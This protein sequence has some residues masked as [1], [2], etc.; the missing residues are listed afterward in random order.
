MQNQNLSIE[1][2]NQEHELASQ[3]LL[4]RNRFSQAL[5]LSRLAELGGDYL[6]RSPINVAVALLHSQNLHVRWAALD[7]IKKDGSGWTRSVVEEA[8]ARETD[9]RLQAAMKSYLRKKRRVATHA[10]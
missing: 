5:F 6:T 4:A 10:A 8:L 9:E 2:A 7:I 3:A 1:R